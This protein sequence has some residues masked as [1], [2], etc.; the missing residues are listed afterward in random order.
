MSKNKLQDVWK[1]EAQQLKEFVEDL[2]LSEKS[3]KKILQ[4]EKFKEISKIGKELNQ[5]INKLRV[6]PLM[7]KY[8]YHRECKLAFIYENLLFH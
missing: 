5:V 7:S 2:K 8:S 6:S 1:E 3:L 4:S